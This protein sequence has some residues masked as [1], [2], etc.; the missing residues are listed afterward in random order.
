VLT[1]ATADLT[2]TLLLALARRVR[3]GERIAR[4]GKLPPW[5]I[6]FLLGTELAG[7]TLGVFGLG[8]IGQAV[9]RRAEAFG[10]R[11]IHHSA[12]VKPG[13]VSFAELLE[14]SDVITIHAP[15][16]D[17][18][19]HA[20]GEAAFARMRP[21]AF[22][23]NTARGPIVDEAALVRALEDGVIAGAGLDVYE[24]EPAIH[25]G[26]LARD[27]VV[28]LPHVGSATYDTRRRMAETAIA[29]AAAV[30]AGKDPPNPV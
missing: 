3:E 17:R 26:L 5:S 30:L 29:N 6:D 14:G 23:L 10:M 4:A 11:V 7:R 16:N 13:S 1:E 24:H 27:D 15:L 2:F 19:R 8:R 9:A 22:V 18:T 25:P 20:F 12:H 21:H 28:L